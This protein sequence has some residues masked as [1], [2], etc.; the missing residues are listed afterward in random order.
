LA[1]SEISIPPSAYDRLIQLSEDEDERLTI[2]AFIIVPYTP[3]MEWIGVVQECIL[4]HYIC[5]K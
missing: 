4:M 3:S 5:G 2:N 1:V